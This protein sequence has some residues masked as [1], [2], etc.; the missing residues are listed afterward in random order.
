MTGFRVGNFAYVSDIREYSE[1]VLDMLQGVEVLVLSALKH[2]PT[3]MHFSIDEAVAFARRTSAK[4][5]Y[6]T[7]IAHDLEYAETNA[8]LPS[9]VRMSYDG[10]EIPIEIPDEELVDCLQSF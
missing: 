3:A 5:I 4:K 8:I 1:Q 6:L 2:I 10:L 7:H 9:D